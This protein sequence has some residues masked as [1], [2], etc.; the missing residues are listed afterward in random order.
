M[1]SFQVTYTESTQTRVV[2]LTELT[3]YP[4]GS[5]VKIFDNSSDV[6]GGYVTSSGIWSLYSDVDIPASKLLTQVN[7]YRHDYTQP[8]KYDVNNLPTTAPIG[9]ELAVGSHLLKSTG[10]ALVS[11]FNNK[12]SR[13]KICF[14][15]SSLTQHGNNWSPTKITIS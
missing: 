11:N 12:M 15:G 5:T 1:I 13:P 9:T 3:A 2:K 7:L 8:P 6:G 4:V 14:V 10:S